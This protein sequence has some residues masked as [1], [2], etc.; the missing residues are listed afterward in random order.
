MVDHVPVLAEVKA[1]RA[2]RPLR[3]SALTS[4]PRRDAWHLSPAGKDCPR[5]APREINNDDGAQTT[6][7][8]ESRAERPLARIGVRPSRARRVGMPV[9]GLMG[10]RFPRTEGS[11]R[12]LA[13]DG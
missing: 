2:A 9:R 1:P 13:G 7:G 8:I 11:L 3:A 4:A 12:N 6:S 5:E 10:I